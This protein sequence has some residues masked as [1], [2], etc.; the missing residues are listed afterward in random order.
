VN[1]YLFFVNAP[2]Y[3]ARNLEFCGYILRETQYVIKARVP[4]MCGF[5]EM[6]EGK[7]DD[8]SYVLDIDFCLQFL[9][10]FDVLFTI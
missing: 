6:F 2:M 10:L 1:I 7:E 9:S 5:G 3:F 8:A 4:I